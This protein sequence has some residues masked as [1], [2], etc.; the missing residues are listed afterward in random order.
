VDSAYDVSLS[1]RAPVGCQRCRQRA[2]RPATALVWAEVFVEPDT[3]GVPRREF[4]IAT[5]A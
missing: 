1:G 4:P 2:H 5:G 3:T